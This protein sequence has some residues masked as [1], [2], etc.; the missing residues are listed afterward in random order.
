MDVSISGVKG[1]EFQYRITLYLALQFLTQIEDLEVIVEPQKGEDILFKFKNKLQKYVIEVQV[2]REKGLLDEEKLLKWACHFEPHSHNECL[3]SRL[4]NSESSALFI[5]KSRCT[6]IT[7]KF[8]INA[9][10]FISYTKENFDDEI[11][12]SFCDTLKKSNFYANTKLGVS[13]NKFVN[14][15]SST[16]K[17]D[18][19]FNKTFNK[20]KII[21]EFNENLLDYEIQRRLNVH[22]SI[23]QSKVQEV[24]LLLIES[25]KTARN[26]GNDLMP[27]LLSILSKFK[28]NSVKVSK[29]YI[30]RDI[31]I[32]LID[33]I[34]KEDVLLLTGISFCGK[35]EIAKKI[36]AE[37]TKK[38]YSYLITSDLLTAESFYFSSSVSDDKILVLEDPFGHIERLPNS[39][40]ISTKLERLVNNLGSNH[41]LIVTSQK[42]I[43]DEIYDGE[44]LKKWID[45]TII[46]QEEAVEFWIKISKIKKIDALVVE[47]IKATIS[48]NKNEKTL[49]I[50]QMEYLSRLDGGEILQ[51]KTNELDTIARYNSKEIAREIIINNKKAGKVLSMLSICGDALSPINI[52]DFAYIVSDEDEKYSLNSDKLSFLSKKT[53]FNFKYNV[54]YKLSK[55]ELGILEYLEERGFIMRRGKTLLFTHPNYFE[56]G[57]Y[58]FSSSLETNQL[59]YLKSHLKAIACYNS[60]ISYFASKEIVFIFKSTSHSVVKNKLVKIAFKGLNSIF[61]ST[62]DNCLIFLISNFEYLDSEQQGEVINWIASTNIDDYDLAWHMNIVPYVAYSSSSFGKNLLIANELTANDIL[63]KIVA[64]GNVST[65]DVWSFLLYIYYSN[66]SLSAEVFETLLLY[67]ESFIRE[68]SSSIFFRKINDNFNENVIKKAFEDEHPLVVFKSLRGVFEVWAKLNRKQKLILFPFLKKALERKDVSIRASNLMTTIGT[69]YGHESIQWKNIPSKKHKEI[70]ELWYELYLIFQKNVPESLDTHTPRFTGTMDDA[71]KFLEKKEYIEILNCWYDRIDRKIIKG[72]MPDDHEFSLALNLMEATKDDYDARKILFEKLIDYN[73]TSFLVS[74]LKWLIS[75]WDFL[76]DN[77]KDKI[78][79]LVNSDREDL[80]WIK[81]VTITSY[82]VPKELQKAIFN[83]IEFLQKGSEYIIQNIDSS[84][85]LDSLCVYFGE[86]QPLWWLAL[87]HR[88]YDIWGEI[89]KEV[90]FKRHSVGFEKCIE[91]F[92]FDG[93]NGFSSDDQEENFK[94]WE[95]VC[96]KSEDLNVETSSLIYATSS[97]TCNIASAKKLWDILISNYKIKGIEDLLIERITNDIVILQHHERIHI[98][99]IIDIKILDKVLMKCTLDY[100]LNVILNKLHRDKDNLKNDKLETALTLVIDLIDEEN[101]L[102]FYYSFELIERA[103]NTLINQEIILKLKGIPNLIYEKGNELKKP[104]DKLRNYKLDNWIEGK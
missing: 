90:I 86:P 58:I 9:D 27:D 6:E 33:K 10:N 52:K 97:C 1:Y 14:S 83:D 79:K 72:I 87:Q 67:K 50:G 26:T 5:T 13:R 8:R 64:K 17:D 41:K 96:Q 94:L 47:K 89:V 77:E 60:D 21:E 99:K 92:L 82:K 40:E 19:V 104:L 75:S 66:E 46:N 38:G 78:T 98:L 65:K 57:R 80:R 62:K 71:M 63:A 30:E 102:K 4:T 20:I 18:K 11:R 16:L 51:K 59:K 12:T 76:S 44:E 23:P 84:L 81:A 70:W 39:F 93:V 24:F 49:Q 68:K 85:L 103:S 101:Y 7:S 73:D 3:L 32:N 28:T 100:H 61:P 55:K 31:E 74:S 88:N 2:K 69:D 48:L 25:I 37:F 91:K 45:L 36:A 34:E 95:N 42:Q 29:N 43:L 53:V 54:K 56:A 22:F 15:L 35:S